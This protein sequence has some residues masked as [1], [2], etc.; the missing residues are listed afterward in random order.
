MNKYIERKI[1]A[2]P[3]LDES[4]SDDESQEVA[5]PVLAMADV[6]QDAIIIQRPEFH[7]DRDLAV[8][9]MRFAHFHV[10]VSGEGRNAEGDL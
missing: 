7:I 5:F 8:H 10:R 4:V 3:K 6:H 9:V 2:L 1:D